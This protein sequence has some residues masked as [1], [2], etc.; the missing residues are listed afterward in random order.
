M[1]P[2]LEDR[3]FELSI[4]LLCVLDFNGRFRR[5]NPAWA[6]TLGFS[7]EE[8][9]AQP[10]IEFVHPEDRART[11]S[12]NGQVRGGS[13]ARLFENRYLHKNGGFRWL[14][15]NSTPDFAREVIYGVARDVTDHK[16]AEDEREA[17]L[18]EL[19]RAHA[20]VSALQAFLPI[21]S[22]CKS[23]R[24]GHD[25]WES[26][27][28]YLAKRTKAQLTHGICPNCYAQIVVP[29]LEDAKQDADNAD[30]P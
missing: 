8:M 22:Y 25:Y 27:E 18:H 2:T 11:V 24:D 26:V 3:F 5:L 4:D 10:F 21:C 16:R 9:L 30:Q 20:E 23:I 29:A 28:A 7:A 1:D 13:Q 6:T 15:W 17:L 12:K 19:Q 14:R